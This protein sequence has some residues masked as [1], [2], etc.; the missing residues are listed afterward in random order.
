MKMNNEEYLSI[1]ECAEALGVS[2]M[3]LYRW[4]RWYNSELNHTN[5]KLPPF[6]QFGSSNKYINKKDLGML[7]EFKSKRRNGMMADYNAAC[8]WGKYGEDI[9]TKRKENKNEIKNIINSKNNSIQ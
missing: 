3:T 5:L 8:H 4:Y 6:Y 2:R 9:L 7:I 1:N